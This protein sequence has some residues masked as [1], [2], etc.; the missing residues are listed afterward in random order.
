M[1]PSFIKH[2]QQSRIWDRTQIGDLRAFVQELLGDE[3]PS[4]YNKSRRARELGAKDFIPHRLIY[5]YERM[6]IS[7]KLLGK[8]SPSCNFLAN[9]ELQFVKDLHT[10]V[11]SH[12]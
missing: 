3:F 4:L 8:D 1:P 10:R 6:E 9:V 7:E 2:K 11:M 5:L 12:N